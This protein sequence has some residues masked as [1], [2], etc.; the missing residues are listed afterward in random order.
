MMG[1]PLCKMIC[2]GIIIAL[3]L[4]VLSLVNSSEKFGN[5]AS[6]L[7]QQKHYKLAYFP[8]RL[9]QKVIGNALENSNAI[10]QD[11]WRFEGSLAEHQR[12]DPNS[13]PLADMFTKKIY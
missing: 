4:V 12:N 6:R 10:L 7:E 2:W 13:D 11:E 9:E 1:E 8:D 5:F 3:I